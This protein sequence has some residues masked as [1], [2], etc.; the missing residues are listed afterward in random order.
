MNQLSF[1]P[2]GGIG[3]VTKNMYIYEYGDEMLIV[4]CGL[5]FADETMLGVDLLLPDISYI[6]QAKKKIVGMVFTHGHEDHIGAL[7]FLL[8]QL[9]NKG[10]FPM[11]ATPFTAAVANEKLKEFGVQKRIDTVNFGETPKHMGSFT[12]LFI[13]VTHSIPDTSHIFI[14]TPIGN[15]YH[16]SDFKFDDTP[17][18]GKKSNYD[19]IE[20][21]GQKGVLCLLSDCLG[22]ERQGRL[23]SEL[24]ILSQ[25]E[26]AFGET[27]GRCIVTT[28]SSNIAR[29]N[30]II[31]ASEK[32]NRK[33]CFIGRSLVKMKDISLRLRYLQI[34][35]QT[36]IQIDQIDSYPENMLTL[37]VAGS[38]GQESSAMVR[39]A[40]NEHRDIRLSEHDTVIFSADPIPGNETLV[41]ELVDTLAKRGVKVLYPPLRRDFHVSGHGSSDELLHLMRLTKPKKLV[42]IGGNFRHM[43]AY[44]NLALSQS[45][46]KSDVLLLDDGQEVLFAKDGTIKLGR[47]VPAKNVYVDEISGEEVESFVM[48]DRQK[49]SEGGVVIVLAE[50]DAQNSEL[51]SKPDIIMRGF[52]VENDSKLYGHM[53]A[54][55][56]TAFR[57]KKG[58]VNN[59]VHLRKLIGEVVERRIFKDLRRR[60]LVLPVVIEA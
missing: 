21:V 50:V 14:T 2:L 53:I 47:N 28:Y 17:F 38:Q 5:G 52:R 8:S 48:R 30:Q 59:W 13:R 23:P 41:Y 34:Q 24:D 45:F 27:Q 56:K 25:F 54:D 3:D 22:A 12:A 40:D 7:P 29:L 6:L 37:I 60:P 42:P 35:P 26:N 43:A 16:G 1:I 49:L 4:D 44:K 18:D 39:I 36:E 9:L 11:Y 31:L 20:Q 51:I 15:F 58:R 10:P 57:G 19:V 33:V 46:Q 55:I 32:Y